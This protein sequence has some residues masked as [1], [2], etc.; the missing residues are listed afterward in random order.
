VMF[1]RGGH[2]ATDI[3]TANVEALDYVEK[4]GL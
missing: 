1:A 4:S 2:D 3:I